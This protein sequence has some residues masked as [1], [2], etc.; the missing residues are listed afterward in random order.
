MVRG[1][2]IGIVVIMCGDLVYYYY[3]LLVGILKVVGNRV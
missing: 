1:E 2:G 3:F